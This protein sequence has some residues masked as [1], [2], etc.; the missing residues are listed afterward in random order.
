MKFLLIFMSF[1]ET[2]KFYFIYCGERVLCYIWYDLLLHVYCYIVIIFVLYF[3]TC[4]FVNLGL[5]TSVQIENINLDIYNSNSH[6]TLSSQVVWA[7]LV[8][9]WSL[10]SDQWISSVHCHTCYNCL[11]DSVSVLHSQLITTLKIDV[12]LV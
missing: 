1:I 7:M 3:I 11:W 6:K 4:H 8:C 2:D 10:H 9:L 5:I 12:F